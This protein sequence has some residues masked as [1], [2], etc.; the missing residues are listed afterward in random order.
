L[1]TRRKTK[2]ARA[3]KIALCLLSFAILMIAR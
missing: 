1:N 2:L 3:R